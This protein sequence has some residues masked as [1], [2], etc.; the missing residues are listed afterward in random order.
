MF[1]LIKLI[2][3]G[4]KPNL[5]ITFHNT[6]GSARPIITVFLFLLCD[7]EGSLLTKFVYSVYTHLTM[8]GIAKYRGCQCCC[9]KYA[10]VQAPFV[11]V[12]TPYNFSVCK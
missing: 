9:T 1:L 10:A 2:F 5:F 12:T 6:S 3:S 7:F 8:K 11:N 4:L